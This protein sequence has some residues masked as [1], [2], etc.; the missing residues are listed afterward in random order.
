MKVSYKKLL[1]RIG[2]WLI[3]EITLN[4]LGVD[5]LADYGE[6]VFENPSWQVTVVY[7]L[8]VFWKLEKYQKCLQLT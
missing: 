7:G 8:P 2:I 4:F 1:V 3:A 5:D 6:F